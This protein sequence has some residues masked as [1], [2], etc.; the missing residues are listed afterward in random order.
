MVRQSDAHAWVEAYFP[1]SGWITFDPTPPALSP[2]MPWMSGFSHY[3]DHL[4]IRWDR[5]IVNYSPLDQAEALAK[6]KNKTDT[7]LSQLQ[8]G[9][10]LILQAIAH[11]VRTIQSLPHRLWVLFTV[12]VVAAILLPILVRAVR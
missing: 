10:I 4:R 7:L 6:V 9:G 5:Y 2:A 8:Q 1:P 12:F 11:G 3:L